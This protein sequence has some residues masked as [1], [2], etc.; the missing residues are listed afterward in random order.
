MGFAADLAPFYADFG[1]TATWRPAVGGAP[2]SGKAILDQP[3]GSLFGGEVIS[4]DTTLRYPVATFPRVEKGDRFTIDGADYLA[5]E[6]ALAVPDGLEA[7]VPLTK[8]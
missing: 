1:V 6:A 4:T 8:L 2:V 7:T 5:R 3:G